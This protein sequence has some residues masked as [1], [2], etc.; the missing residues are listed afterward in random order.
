MSLERLLSRPAGV[1]TLAQAVT[2]GM[3]ADTVARRARDGV[4]ERLHPG[5]YL[6][7]GHRLTDEARVRAACLWAGGEPAAVTGPAAAF[8]HGMR[9][10]APADIEVTVPRQRHLRARPGIVVRRRD[11]AWQDQIGTHDLWLAAKPF[12][13]LGTAVALPDGSAFLDRALQNHVRF[14]ALYRSYCRNLG[15]EG[16]SVAGRLITA[17]ADRAD[18]AAEGLLVRLLRGAGITGWV[19]GHPFGPYRS[20]WRSLPRRWRSRWTAGR[21]TSTRRGSATT[22]AR[23]TSSPSAD[24]ISCVSPGTASTRAGGAIAEIAATLA[25]ARVERP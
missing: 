9:D 1:L 18:S 5:V 25:I 22:G 4:R 23:A 10:R 24:G 19:L 8:W 11:L 3:P 17:A 21:G 16:S 7:G 2:C 13:A 15:R 6:V 12:A 14:P 20:T